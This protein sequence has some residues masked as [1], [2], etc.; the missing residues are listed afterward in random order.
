GKRLNP[1]NIDT[2][3]SEVIFASNRW[4]Y[5]TFYNRNRTG[6]GWDGS[7]SKSERKQLLSNGFEL[8][9]FKDWLSILRWRFNQEYTL[10]MK[11]QWG[12][13][14][15]ASDFLQNRNVRI[16]SFGLGPEVVW[17]PSISLRF[18]GSYQ[19][20]ERSN[21]LADQ[22]E[23][24]KLNEI[25][26]TITWNQLGKG[27]LQ[28]SIKWLQIDYQGEE[29]TYSA[30]QL[31]EALRPGNNTTWNVNWQQSLG[32]GI[33]MTLQYNGRTSEGQ[34]PIHTGTVVMTAYF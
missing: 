24:S 4:S 17:Q 30:Y 9:E 11:N 28:G 6:L 16:R 26:G 3:S 7:F 29:N 5:S 21:V 1:F 13:Q 27:N 12:R 18:I 23:Q 34:S 14:Q 8:S 25:K 15:N 2:E 32:R 33:Q 10:Q 22:P 31:L 20:R 19:Y